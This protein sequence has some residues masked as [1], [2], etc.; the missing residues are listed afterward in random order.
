MSKNFYTTCEPLVKKVKEGN[1]F[2]EFQVLP[3]KIINTENLKKSC[4]QIKKPSKSP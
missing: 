3:S 1:N 2:W 4:I